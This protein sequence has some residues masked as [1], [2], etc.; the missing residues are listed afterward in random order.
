V[1]DVTTC[2]TESVNV[3]LHPEDE[4][5]TILKNK[6]NYLPHDTVLQTRSHAF[7]EVLVPEPTGFTL[8]TYTDTM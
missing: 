6:Q 7:P 1:Q 3:N 2:C 4:G 8:N 5:T